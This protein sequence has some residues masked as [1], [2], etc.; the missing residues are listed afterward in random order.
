MLLDVC[1]GLGF[2]ADD[3]WRQQQ[4]RLRQRRLSHTSAAARTGSSSEQQEGD[5]AA[6]GEQPLVDVAAAAGEAVRQDSMLHPTRSADLQVRA[7]LG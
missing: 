3:P 4:V 6:E 2:A 7:G 1:E 5:E